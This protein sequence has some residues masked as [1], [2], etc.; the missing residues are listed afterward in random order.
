MLGDS[1]N[2]KIDEGLAQS[3]F[4]VVILSPAFLMKHTGQR[5]SYRGSVQETKRGV[6]VVNGSGANG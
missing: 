2:G 3:R 1:L 5:K 6:K 4:G